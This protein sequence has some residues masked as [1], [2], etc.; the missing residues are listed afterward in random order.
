MNRKR[1]WIATAMLALL[2]MG[3]ALALP[4]SAQT[5]S[6]M[7]GD[8]LSWSFDRETETLTISGKGDMME[9][10][11]S[12]DLPW[13]NIREEV[14]K[15][16]IGK[17]VTSLYAEAFRNFV[18]LT[19][20]EFNATNMK[21]LPQSNYAFYRAGEE[22]GGYTLTVG[23]NVTRIP[24][25]LFND[26]GTTGDPAYLTEIVFQSGSV[27]REIG[28]NAFCGCELLE[29]IDLPNTVQCI[30]EGAFSFTGLTEIKLGKKITEIGKD[31]FSN[32]G[33]TEI[34]IPDGVKTIASGTFYGCEDLE[35]V[36]LGKGV[37]SIGDYAFSGCDSLVTLDLPAKLKSI[38]EHAFE[39]CYNLSSITIPDSVTTIGEYAFV[40]CQNLKEVKLSKGLTSMGGSAFIGC[41][42]LKAV[43]IPAS[44]IEIP[45]DAFSE[46]TSLKEI[47]I[48]DT[49]TKIGSYAFYGCTDLN[50]VTIG[51][52]V[53]YIYACAFADCTALTTVYFNA[54]EMKE[55]LYT[56]GFNGFE[57]AGTKGT[58]IE[59]VVG[60]NV[61]R[62]PSGL[63]CPDA[64]PVSAVSL[65]NLVSVRFEEGSVC[66]EIADYAFGWCPSLT[67]I[68][69][70]DSLEIIGADAFAST[71]I[72]SITIPD[73]VTQM[74]SGAFAG[75]KRLAT[76]CVTSPVWVSL[77]TEQNGCYGLL[78]Y[79][80]TVKI[81][82][83]ITDVPTYLPNTYRYVYS[84]DYP[85][86][87]SPGVSY[88][89]YSQIPCAIQHEHIFQEGWKGSEN[90][91]GHRCI[92]C[93]EVDEL[94]PHEYEGACETT[95]RE[96]GSIREPRHSFYYPCDSVCTLCGF[97][98]NV[99]HTYDNDCD[100]KCHYCKEV[101]SIT[102]TY[103]DEW[104]TNGESHWKVCAICGEQGELASHIWD[105][106]E[107]TKEPTESAEG[108]RVHTCLCGERKT[109]SVPKM[110]A[111][112][113]DASKEADEDSH[114]Q[115]VLAL[116]GAASLIAVIATATV[117]LL[118][119]KKN[120]EN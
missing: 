80:Q 82:S 24:G 120:A 36:N 88:T 70:P 22:S 78:R 57:G 108:E 47:V 73:S 105:E 40:D 81:D 68:T 66:R 109:V 111:P 100:P 53:K 119:K 113:L 52:G 63:F 89:V 35:T 10:S 118:K 102:H 101:R 90:G 96:C 16:V 2:V 95:C 106:G 62:I 34:T 112:K 31:A 26:F 27:C 46:C 71:S 4:V 3:M 84:V 17:G 91:H 33:L 117:V 43:E 116:A 65:L 9:C 29:A 60:A 44:L 83:S 42:K 48:P 30:G 79:A 75:C 104:S 110:D 77:M 12:Y 7:C 64:Y 115:T 58:G 55:N 6:G 37:E 103:G 107:V 1:L 74:G 18:A 99:S 11:G 32:V 54:T 61:T 86:I 8:Q 69:L 38:G 15:I 25:G 97:T 14:E 87:H 93:D 94:L 5:S 59:L 13:F 19:E 49:V 20:I 50:T 41:R 85:G 114:L 21:D 72:T 39:E 56:I 45:D 92:S 76:V 23:A 67:E 28:D 98:R 51:K